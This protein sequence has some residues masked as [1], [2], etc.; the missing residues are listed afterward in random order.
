MLLQ[1]LVMA[2]WLPLGRIFFRPS[3]RGREH[4]RTKGGCVV[5]PVHLSGFDALAVGYGMWPRPARTMGKVE[6]FRRPW[7]GPLVRS[8]GAFPAND[9]EGL[10]GGVPAAAELAA[11]GDAVVIYPEGARRRGRVRRPHTGAARVALAAGVPL[12]PVA[13]RGTDGWRDR[14][15]WKIVFGEPLD[16]SDLA[17]RD[18]DEAAHEATGRVWDAVR[19]LEGRLEGAG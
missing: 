13:L 2:L 11:A 19:R 7:L 15:R 18:P 4:V 6:L 9:G 12:I 8:L 10:P 5:C 1:R 16:V 14:K 17:G 3:V